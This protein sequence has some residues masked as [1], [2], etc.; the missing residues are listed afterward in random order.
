M[1]FPDILYSAARALR[2]LGPYALLELV[3]PGGTL[4]ALLLFLYR[5]RSSAGRDGLRGARAADRQSA[6]TVGDPPVGFPPSHS[7]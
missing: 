7:S 2:A 6:E 1:N 5:R 3:M 4:L